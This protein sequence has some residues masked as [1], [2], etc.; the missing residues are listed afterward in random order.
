M[1]HSNIQHIRNTVTVTYFPLEYYVRN[2]M[3]MYRFLRRAASIC[4][5]YRHSPRSEL[6]EV[7]LRNADVEV[8]CCRHH[9]AS[10]LHADGTRVLERGAVVVREVTALR[11]GI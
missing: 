1:M 8:V 6:V 7:R 11:I 5:F 3:Y 9:V 4:S 2:Y 10:R